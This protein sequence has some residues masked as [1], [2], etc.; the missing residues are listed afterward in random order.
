MGDLEVLLELF[1]RIFHL[2]DAGSS[3]FRC[4]AYL[5]ISRAKHKSAKK[6]QRWGWAGMIFGVETRSDQTKAICLRRSKQTC[7]C[8]SCHENCAR[9]QPRYVSATGEDVLLSKNTSLALVWTFT[10]PSSHITSGGSQFG[11]S[12]LYK[13]PRQHS[14]TKRSW[15]MSSIGH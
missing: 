2:S 8:S 3:S 14:K 5:R 1:Q 7:H 4:L 15:K 9:I 13:S 10:P 11:V 12:Q 6:G